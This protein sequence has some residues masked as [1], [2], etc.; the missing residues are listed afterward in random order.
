MRNQYENE[1]FGLENNWNLQNQEVVG[2]GEVL[3]KITSIP[4]NFCK[5]FLLRNI[6]FVVG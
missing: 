2:W 4:S 1:I 5:Y 6:I 3:N